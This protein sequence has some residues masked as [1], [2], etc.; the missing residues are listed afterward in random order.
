MW[1]IYLL[2][3]TAIGMVLLLQPNA[4]F[5]IGPGHLVLSA[6]TLAILIACSFDRPPVLLDH[7]EHYLNHLVH[8]VMCRILP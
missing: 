8:Q 2:L 6:V 5:A 7:I 1:D 3:H 4:D